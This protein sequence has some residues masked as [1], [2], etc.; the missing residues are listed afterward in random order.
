M[1]QFSPLQ[2]KFEVYLENGLYNFPT[3][4]KI[5]FHDK[6]Y[7]ICEDGVHTS[8]TRCIHNSSERVSKI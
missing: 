3:S 4:N 1:M 5:F 6:L 8:G 2:T 7:G